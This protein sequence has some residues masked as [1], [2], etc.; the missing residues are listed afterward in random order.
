LVAVVTRADTI[1]FRSGERISGQYAGGSEGSVRFQVGQQTRVYDRSQIA[2]ISFDRPKAPPVA[3]AEPEPAT[4][5]PAGT[6]LHV[7]V[8]QGISTRSAAPGQIF[9]GVLESAL[10][11]KGQQV[12]PAGTKVY[13]KL[14]HVKRGGRVAGRAELALILDAIA[15]EGR[16]IAVATNAA[17]F[18]G[19]KQG[20][21]GMI[22]AGAAIGGVARGR[23]GARRGAAWGTAA[24]VLTPGK[25]INIPAGTMLDFTTTVNVTLP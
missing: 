15:I 25:Q 9:G 2:S 13:G 1:E 11:I 5:L 22:G 4:V 23:R 10:F 17:A 24:A 6:T 19:S 14:A 3:Q 18:R 16:R 21:A 12:A 8:T 7:R 20:S